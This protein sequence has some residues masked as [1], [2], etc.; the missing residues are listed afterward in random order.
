MNKDKRR[1]LSSIQSRID[2]IKQEVNLVLSQEQ[3]C[4]DNMPESLEGTERYERFENSVENLEDTIESLKDAIK[5]IDE[6]MN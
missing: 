1:T 2:E 5:F 4:L 6:A 3:S